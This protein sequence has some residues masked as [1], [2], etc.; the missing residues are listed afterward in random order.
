M[1]G[2]HNIKLLHDRLLTAI[3]H[4]HPTLGP[5]ALND[6]TLISFNLTT[7]IHKL[8]IMHKQIVNK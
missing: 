1:L 3:P 6:H 7:D 8:L 2:T 4:S 5:P